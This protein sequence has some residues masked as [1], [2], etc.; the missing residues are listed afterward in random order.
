MPVQMKSLRACYVPSSRR[1]F[2]ANQFFEA[3]DER[4]ADRLT[5]QKRAV[6]VPV[7]EEASAV[8]PSSD[9]LFTASQ[10][11]DDDAPAPKRRNYQRRDMRADD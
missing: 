5:R 7:Q 3:A 4:E 8:E 9:S 10:S 2:N 6:R 11:A 1:E